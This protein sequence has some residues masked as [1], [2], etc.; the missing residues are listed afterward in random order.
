MANQTIIVAN[1]DL[2]YLDMIRDLLT[3]E[4]YS[5][6]IVAHSPVAYQVIC[7]QTPAL[8]LLDIHVGQS[9]RGWKTLNY[10]RLNPDTAHIPVIICS[11]DPRLPRE[12]EGWLREQHCDFLEKPFTFD[13]LLEK[14]S[15]II[16]L[17]RN[18]TD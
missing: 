6:V 14:V 1:D 8:V 12:K 3:D 11:T 18:S 13:Q 4:G 9:D 2:T 15:A 7:E 17:P 16:G 5:S 10:M